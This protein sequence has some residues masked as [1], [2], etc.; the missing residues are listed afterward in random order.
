MDQDGTDGIGII[1]AHVFPGTSRIRAFI[2][3]VTEADVSAHFCFAHPHINNVWIGSRHLNGADRRTA[4]NGI[5]DANPGLPGIGRF[6]N[7]T[8]DG[9]GIEDTRLVLDT[10]HSKTPTATPWSNASPPEAV[11]QRRIIYRGG[12]R[13]LIF[14]HGCSREEAAGKKQKGKYPLFHSVVI[15]EFQKNKKQV[16]EE[17][18]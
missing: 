12:F 11:E 15:C 3:T 6:P 10:G 4:K 14:R 9:T 8:T 13:S 7:A 2:H 16:K 5:A 18:T 1:Q 17:R